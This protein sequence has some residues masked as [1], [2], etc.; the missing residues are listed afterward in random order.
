VRSRQSTFDPLVKL[1]FDDR[2]HGEEPPNAAQ[3]ASPGDIQWLKDNR[4]PTKNVT[5]GM[6]SKLREQ[7]AKWRRDGMASWRHRHVLA[8]HHCPVDVP[9]EVAGEIVAHIKASNWQ[10]DMRV[11]ERIVQNGRKGNAVPSDL[12]EIPW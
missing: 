2:H 7:A 4:L 9:F 5:R 6:V 1:G 11:V 12:D 10:P 3:P 8:R